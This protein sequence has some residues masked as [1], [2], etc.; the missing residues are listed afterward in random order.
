MFYKGSRLFYCIYKKRLIWN[1]DF[2]KLE[3]ETLLGEK[4][5]ILDYT[6][7]DSLVSLEVKDKNGNIYSIGHAVGSQ[8]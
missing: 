1:E 8:I 6:L 3:K 4:V 2:N 7:T 5:E